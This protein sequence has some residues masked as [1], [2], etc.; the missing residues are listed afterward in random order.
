MMLT[1]LLKGLVIAV[2]SV[3]H[4]PATAPAVEPAAS[5]QQLAGLPPEVRLRKLHLVR[6]DLIPFPI[7]YDVYC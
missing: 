6:P 4:A 3:S 5:Q 2:A 7:A 1:S